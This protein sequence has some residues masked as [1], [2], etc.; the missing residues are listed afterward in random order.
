MKAFDGSEL[1][2]IQG[3]Q[4]SLH[5]C[6]Y[7]NAIFLAER[8]FALRKCEETAYLLATSCIRQNK[9][10]RASAVLTGCQSPENRYL[11]AWCFFEQNKLREAEDSL[12]W[13]E[14]EEEIPGKAAGHYLLGLIYQRSNRKNKAIDQFKKCLE[15]DATLWMAYVALCELGSS[16]DPDT[17]FSKEDWTL[18][19]TQVGPSAEAGPNQPLGLSCLSS[20]S[21]EAPSI[22]SGKQLPPQIIGRTSEEEDYNTPYQRQTPKRLASPS[23]VSHIT[24]TNPNLQTNV[25]DKSGD[26]RTPSPEA[27]VIGTL[28]SNGPPSVRRNNKPLSTPSSQQETIGSLRKLGR[29]SFSSRSSDRMAVERVV[30][31]GEERNMAHDSFSVMRLFRILGKAQL[32]LSLFCSEEAI[33]TL[34]G[35]PPAQYQTGYVLSMVDFTYTDGLEYFSSVMW[36]L[37]M[38]TE[39]SFLSQYLLSVDRNSSSA[40]CAMGNLFSLQK[41]P[42]TAIRCLKRAVL[43]AP[44]SSYAHAL[45]G[46]EYIFKED[47][48]AAMASFRTALAISEREY[49]AWYGLGQVFHKQEKYKLADYHYR[50]AIKINPRSSLLYYHL[51]NVCYSCKSYNEALEA[52]DKAIE[53][54]AKNYVARFERAKLYS[55][56]QRH[57]EATEE[58]IELSNLVPKE[59]AVHYLLGRLAKNGGDRKLAM[60]YFMFALDLDPKSRLYKHCLENIDAPDDPEDL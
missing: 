53:L 18:L 34:E 2:L 29:L 60:Q 52:Y 27:K 3:V 41:D 9:V 28:R 38:E 37:R 30:S 14:K 51:A 23:R 49:H 12:R 55:K 47:Y 5:Y 59:P 7:S 19:S 31:S 1:L 48:D 43:L 24:L 42:D 25:L 11:A 16:P 57:R 32:L 22:S 36:H 20:T 45:I 58:L 46:H 50:C 44:R 15:K 56:I 26:F 8:L 35:L 10:H 4:N 39:L 6:L 33:Q 54:N 17:Y 21:V 13:N 40:W